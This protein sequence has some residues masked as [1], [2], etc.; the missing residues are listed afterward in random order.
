MRPR[1]RLEVVVGLAEVAAA[2]AGKRKQERVRQQILQL[3]PA[4][5]KLRELK[6]ALPDISEA[7]VRIVLNEL[8]QQG[9]VRTEGR[10]AGA[11]WIRTPTR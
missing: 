7:T 10:G 4:R 8:R 3:G 5:F 1:T 11:V 6:L 2:G 9:L